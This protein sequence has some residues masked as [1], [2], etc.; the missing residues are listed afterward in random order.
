MP[1][2]FMSC[3]RFSARQA[4][5]ALLALI[6]LSGCNDEHTPVRK[7]QGKALRRDLVEEKKPDTQ[8]VVAAAFHYHFI[9]LRNKDKATRDSA[10]AALKALSAG[11]RNIILRLNRVDAASYK[12]LDTMV[13]PDKIDTDWMAYCIFPP[14]LPVLKDV[15]KMVFFAYYPQAF[16]AYENGKL[17]RWGPTNM[18]KKASPTPT[19]LFS[20]NWKALETV[21][22]VNDEWVLKWNFNVWNKGGIGW[23]QYQLP[24]Y[25]ASHSCMRLLE[26]DA[27]YM[28][29]WADQWIVK[30]DLL[31]AQGT[32][33]LIFGHYPFGGHK[34][35]WSLVEDPAALNIPADTMTALLRP[36]LDKILARQ[37]QRD[38]V[39]SS[40]S[41]GKTVSAIK[42]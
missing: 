40:M 39:I 17:I 25:P 28:Y 22:T 4:L 9:S 18:G 1:V 33:V 29:T 8:R 7:T 15:R 11:E 31:A 37:A 32:P 19:G 24:G 2:R 14:E 30:D 26:E 16:A 23:H 20:C 27:K 13:I 12:R 6:V 36:H 21:S 3:S 42:G 38:S 35:W 41:A 5:F 34:P 10:A